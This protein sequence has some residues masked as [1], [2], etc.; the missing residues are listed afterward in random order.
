[1]K[2]CL[3]LHNQ[4]DRYRRLAGVIPWVSQAII[5]TEEDEIVRA[6]LDRDAALARNLLARHIERSVEEIGNALKREALLSS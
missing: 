3:Q 4:F 6:A 2:F 1:L 5:R